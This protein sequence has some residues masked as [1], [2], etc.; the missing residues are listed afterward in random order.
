MGVPC[1]FW[2]VDS[3][4]E[5]EEG[6]GPQGSAHAIRSPIQGPAGRVWG[7]RAA[8][9]SES[10]ARPAALLAAPGVSSENTRK[11]GRA[12]SSI[13]GGKKKKKGSGQSIDPRRLEDARERIDGPTRAPPGGFRRRLGTRAGAKSYLP[14]HTPVVFDSEGLI[15][16]LAGFG[17]LLGITC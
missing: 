17:T 15:A 13:D 5:C 2:G 8:R 14:F 16:L 7:A 12:R 4:R 1:G 9:E 10:C 3:G 6:A 11:A